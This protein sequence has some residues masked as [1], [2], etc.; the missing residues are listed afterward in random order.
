MTSERVGRYTKPF[1]C[2]TC[3]EQKCYDSA[4]GQGRASNQSRRA[5]AGGGRRGGGINGWVG[6][7][8]HGWAGRQGGAT[9]WQTDILVGMLSFFLKI[10][11]ARRKCYQ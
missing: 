11:P 6:M 10:Y 4:F 1:S 5:H 3:S 8:I 2:K 9:K 7:G